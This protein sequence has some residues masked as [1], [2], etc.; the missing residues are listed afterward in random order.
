MQVMDQCC[1]ADGTCPQLRAAAADG[2]FARFCDAVPNQCDGRGRLTHL[3]LASEGL[4]CPFP[5]A[6]NRLAA[7]TRLDLTF[8]KLDGRCA[9][10][11]GME[12]NF[13]KA[14]QNSA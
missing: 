10:H 7:L 2:R 9:P 4:A 8:N 14:I 6:L 3:S 5:R 1:A 12:F 13:K 11:Q